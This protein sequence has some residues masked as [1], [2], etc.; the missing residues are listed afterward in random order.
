MNPDHRLMRINAQRR[1]KASKA[2]ELR[3]LTAIAD[4]VFSLGIAK[5]PA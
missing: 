3:A 4:A 1:T 5:E 2:V